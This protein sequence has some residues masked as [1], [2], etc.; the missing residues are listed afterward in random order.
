M[1]DNSFWKWMVNGWGLGTGQGA[2]ASLSEAEWSMNRN[3]SDSDSITAPVAAAAVRPC[4]LAKVTNHDP[5]LLE[6][7]ARRRRSWKV[8]DGEKSSNV[9]AGLRQAT[10]T[11]PRRFAP[12]W[13]LKSSHFL[14]FFYFPGTRVRSGLVAHVWF[15]QV[16]LTIIYRLLEL[17]CSELSVRDQRSSYTLPYKF[18]QCEPNG[19]KP[20]TEYVKVKF[21]ERKKGNNI[22]TV[23]RAIKR[24]NLQLPY[25]LPWQTHS[26]K[27]LFTDFKAY[28]WLWV[29]HWGFSRLISCHNDNDLHKKKEMQA[30]LWTIQ[31]LVRLQAVN[32]CKF[33]YGDQRARLRS[34]RRSGW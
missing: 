9:S 5:G 34:R 1:A 16:H 10:T 27:E 7:C 24:C 12:V 23:L 22:T 19:A 6:R 13:V 32:T 3:V 11:L 30:V 20:P 21:I 18:I 17:P 25:G 31:H 15:S 2:R 29:A 8:T 28:G 26:S 33:R 14:V 4:Q